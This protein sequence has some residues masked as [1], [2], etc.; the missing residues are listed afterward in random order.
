MQVQGPTAE[1]VEPLPEVLS[2]SGL[3]SGSA[4]AI[5]SASFQLDG[6]VPMSQMSGGGLPIIM[7]IP[8]IPAVNLTHIQQV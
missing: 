7:P 1:Q 3:P 8:H 6:S 2:Q 5:S 4:S